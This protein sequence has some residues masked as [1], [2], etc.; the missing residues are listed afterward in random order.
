MALGLDRASLEHDIEMELN[1]LND[2]D[3]AQRL[4]RAIAAIIEKNN[5]EIERNLGKRFADIERIIG[6]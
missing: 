5:R 3:Q 2:K 6:R 4:A 1:A